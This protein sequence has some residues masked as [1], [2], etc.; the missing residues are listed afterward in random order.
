[1]NAA[2]RLQ[3]S[4]FG[5]T[6]NAASGGAMLTLNGGTTTD[7]DVPSGTLLTLAGADPIVISLTGSGHEG[8][9]AGQ[10]FMQDGAH[11]LLGTNAGEIT[12]TGSN[13][14]TT[15]STYNA[16]T[17]PFG[18]GTTGSVVFQTGAT[19]AFHGGLDPFGGANKSVA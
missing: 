8:T 7:L 11:P 2:I 5:V 15:D 13:A 10:L 3:N 4:V 14:F 17:H 18:T 16:S 1:T 9:I 6:L 19:G 12:M